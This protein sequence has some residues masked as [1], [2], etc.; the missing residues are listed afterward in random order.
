MREKPGL[1]RDDVGHHEPPAA[2]LNSAMRVW[3]EAEA[4][5]HGFVVAAGCGPSAVVVARTGAWVIAA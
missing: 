3:F 2:A 4:G 5:Y 1:T